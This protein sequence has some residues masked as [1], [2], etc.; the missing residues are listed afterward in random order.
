[1]NAKDMSWAQV[2]LVQ[3]TE[4]RLVWGEWNEKR[5]GRQT[6]ASSGTDL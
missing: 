1:M 4:T 5:L 3:G 6:V 2:W